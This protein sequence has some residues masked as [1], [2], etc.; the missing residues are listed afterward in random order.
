MTVTLDRG[1]DPK[2]LDGELTEQIY[3]QLLERRHSYLNRKVKKPLIRLWDKEFN[4]LTRIE[5]VDRWMWE[6]L[7]TDDGTAEITFSG[8]HQDW[9]REIVCIDTRVEEDLHIT[10][11][12]DPDNPT[13]WRNRWGGKVMTIEDDETAGEAPVTTLKCISNRRHLKGI[14]LAA[15]PIFPME[16]QLPKMYLWG[17]PCAFTCASSTFI[18]LFRLY[19]LNG[20]F[21]IPRNVFA[22]ETWLQNIS[23]LNWPVQVMP[24]NPITDQ[25]RW[26]TIGSRWKDAH[27]V[28][29][30]PMKDAGV[31]C[32]AYTWLPGDPPPY[33]MF[34]ETLAKI[35]KPTRACVI[36]SF[37]DKSG[38]TGPTGTLLDGALNLMAATLDDLI[39][40]TI[41]PLDRDLD[42][43]TDP[44]FRKLLLVAPKPPPVVYRDVGFGN[45]KKKK[46]VIHKSQATDII[47][48]GKSPGWVNQAITFAIR[49]G[50]SQ[51]GA[52]IT[53]GLGAYATP[54][55]EGLDNLYQ[56]QLDDVF[57]AFQRFV[58]PIRSA[59]A[60]SYAFREH[61]ATN[62]GTAYV[63]NAIQGIAIGD[64]EMRAYS[65]MKF[66]VGEGPYV[67]GQDY[68]LGDRVSAEIRQI[69]Y[70]DQILAARAEGTREQ[71][72]DVQISFG[73]DSREENPIARG[74]RTI[75]TVANFAAMLAGSGDLF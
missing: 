52:T 26:C 15:N 7:A 50:L 27:T 6:E 46:R 33:T 49:Y 41:I 48:G 35:L 73:D 28:F 20:W 59:Q 58:N 55:A 39:T 19:T 11:D 53:Y 10:I 68:T 18:N 30:A 1:I 61:F 64:E 45:V 63:L 12:P 21:P 23:P 71:P 36:L 4:F 43:E 3:M 32:R 17:G 38:V 70:T 22:P 56:G 2:S 62:T 54:G 24:I 14:Y 42:G 69:T 57:L 51:L 66:D 31:I 29:Q 74:F 37:E 75:G 5:D 34:G 67:W 25:S 8:S 40:E 60:G 16:V 47:I 72:G 65:S 9:L 44:F 13:D